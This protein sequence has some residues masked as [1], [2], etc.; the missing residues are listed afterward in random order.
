MK[1]SSIIIIFFLNLVYLIGNSSAQQ[2][3]R[4][5]EILPVIAVSGIKNMTGLSSIDRTS[6]LIEETLIRNLDLT[7]K[8][9]TFISN[10]GKQF[11]D[12]SGMY[13]YCG[14]NNLSYLIYGNVTKTGRDIT[15]EVSIFNATHNGGHLSVRETAET[16]AKLRTSMDNIFREVFR[17]FTHENVSF[18]SISF[19]NRGQDDGS[20]TLFIDGVNIGRNIEYIDYLVS[21]SRNI[22]ILQNRMGSGLILADIAIILKPE[23]RVS[24]E[25]EIP[26]LTE[27]EKRLISRYEKPI[28]LYSD[29]KFKSR[30]VAAAFDSVLSLLED[31]SFCS[32][33]VD[34]KN[35]IAA[36]YEIWKKNM[37]E[38]G[39]SRGL[40]AADLPYS[41]GLKTMVLTS[42][43]DISD[44]DMAGSKPQGQSSSSFGGGFFC[45]ADIFESSGIQGE[46]NFYNQKI[47]ASFDSGYPLADSSEMETSAWYIEFPLIVYYRIPSH[48][49]KFYAGAALKYRT[50]VMKVDITDK[51]TGTSSG[52][53]YDEGLLRMANSS[54]LAGGSLEFPLNSSLFFLDFRYSRDFYSWFESSAPEEDFIASYIA[55]SFGYTIKGGK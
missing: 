1:K 41:A 3:V 29:D 5:P 23:D 18:A 6:E 21:G 13:E 7:G 28:D 31:P 9:R 54:W 38:W 12:E 26:S 39:L 44:W 34:K 42:T 46:F 27:K 37:S 10:D 8:F 49:L 53:E 25:F 32:S 50:T 2:T 16:P 19:V 51:A 33:A 55:C 40:T 48:L 22:R 24:I 4:K 17:F 35:D 20:Y 15:I 52:S 45:S 47:P 14:E 30:R 36:K 43:Y 11:A